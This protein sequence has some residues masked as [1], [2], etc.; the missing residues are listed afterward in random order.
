[1]KKEKKNYLKFL[2][3]N[4]KE[5]EFFID[6]LAVL[7]SSGMTVLEAVKA[8]R[9]EIKTIFLQKITKNKYK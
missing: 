9:F 1:M 2:F 4:R 3:L 6:N 8:I 7:I 5:L